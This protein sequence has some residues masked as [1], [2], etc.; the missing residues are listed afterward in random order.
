MRVSTSG[1]GRRTVAES[2]SGFVM[3]R[4][5]AIAPAGIAL[6]LCWPGP[7]SAA[8]Y[9]VRWGDTLS[10]IASRFGTSVGSLADAN[11][12]DPAGTLLAG[13]VLRVPGASAPASASGFQ[14][15]ER[16]S[17]IASRFGT[18]VDALAAA[19]RLD[20]GSI[21]L[22]GITVRVPGQAAPA[23]AAPVSY[24][25]RPGDALG[26]IAARLGTSVGAL[27]AANRLDP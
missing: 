8:G 24:V 23:V 11:R 12:L 22:A 7:A 9:Q 2:G 16:L 13:T 25:V 26:A 21:L 5:S 18:T 19:N 1:R 3:R 20:A 4:L 10:A 27:A 15:Q 6:L 17:G 14:V